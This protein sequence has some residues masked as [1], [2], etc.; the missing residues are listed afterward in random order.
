M[1]LEFGWARTALERRDPAFKGRIGIEQ[2]QDAIHIEHWRPY[3]RMASHAVHPSATFLRFSLGA[4]SDSPIL[5]AGVSNVDL[6]DPGQ[7]A[8]LSLGHATA[9]LLTYDM[10][11]DD[12]SPVFKRNHRPCVRR[13]LEGGRPGQSRN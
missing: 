1:C 7:G 11:V 10:D 8:L 3:Y 4:P 2:I 5:L 13:L 12:V 9:A 6:F